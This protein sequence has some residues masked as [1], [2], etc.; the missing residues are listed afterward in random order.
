MQLSWLIGQRNSLR[1]AENKE[2]V[3]DKAV[4]IRPFWYMRSQMHR[5]HRV[6]WEKEEI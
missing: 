1:I 6:K 4:K 2:S 3:T 5:Y